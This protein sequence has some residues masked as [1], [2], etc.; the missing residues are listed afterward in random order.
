[1]ADPVAQANLA[2]PSF[3]PPSARAAGAVNLTDYVT[4]FGRL[5]RR[6]IVLPRENLLE[7]AVAAFKAAAA[8]V[9]PGDCVETLGLWIDE[10]ALPLV[11]RL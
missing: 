3:L 9:G 10:C 7:A 1:M 2:L 4:R 8:E 6:K 11:L 5:R